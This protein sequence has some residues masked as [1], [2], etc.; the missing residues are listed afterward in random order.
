MGEP[1]GANLFEMIGNDPVNRTDFLGLVESSAASQGAMILLASTLQASCYGTSEIVIALTRLISSRMDWAVEEILRHLINGGG[2]HYNQFDDP[3]WSSY[4]MASEALKNRMRA[5]WLGKF[6]EIKRGPNATTVQAI[7]I[8]ETTS[9]ALGR[10]NWRDFTG[11][12][13]INGANP[14]VEIRG[15]LTSDCGNK[16]SGTFRYTFRDRL[17]ANWGVD[18]DMVF[19]ALA[20]AGSLGNAQPLEAS[21]LWERSFEFSF[22]PSS[23]SGW[24]Y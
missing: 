6:A 21:F 15:K 7:D 13:L 19:Y 8:N 12:G 23:N 4:M 9:A 20:K 16:F 11:Y 10:E 24:P 22:I 17:D 2:S 5:F 18:G 1:G 14:G 3:S